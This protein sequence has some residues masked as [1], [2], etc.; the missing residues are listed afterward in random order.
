ME[1]P[2]EILDTIKW[3]T[4]RQPQKGGQ[5]CG[6]PNYGVKLTSEEMGFEVSTDAFRTQWQ[7]KE[8]CMTVFELF[9]GEIKAI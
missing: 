9:L 8:F 7:A 5:Q 4:H 1:I 6:I 2:K 3:S